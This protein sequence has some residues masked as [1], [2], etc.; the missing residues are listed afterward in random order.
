M[1]NILIDD[2]PL[3]GF[4]PDILEYTYYV[5]T[6]PKIQAIPEDSTAQVSD[7]GYELGQPFSIFV[8][9][10]DGSERV[11][12]INFEESAINAARTPLPTDVIVKH[13]NGTQIAFATL[14]KNVSVGIYS[15]QSNLLF[16]A[17]VPECSQND[18]TIIID[19]KGQEK[20]VDIHRYNVTYTLPQSDIPYIYV[21]FENE[22]RKIKSGIILRTK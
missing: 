15:A 21:F 2:V 5:T 14:R 3:L 6:P 16:Y 8:D 11:Y 9:A 7:S 12:T 22:K 18:A 4:D 19:E 1:A 13:L 20:L 17:K 10:P